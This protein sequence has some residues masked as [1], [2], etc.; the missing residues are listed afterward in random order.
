MPA[1]DTGKSGVMLDLHKARSAADVYEH[2]A[3]TLALGTLV[4]VTLRGGGTDTGIMATAIALTLP[5]AIVTKPW[6]RVHPGALVL[7]TAVPLTALVTALITPMAFTDS[8]DLAVYGYG[9]AA[10]LAFLGYASTRDRRRV[11]LVAAAVVG[12]IAF[13]HALL[14]WIGGGDPRQAMV[15]T[16]YELDMFGTFCVGS[17][18]LGFSLALF[19]DWWAKVA[20]W[21]IGPACAAGVILSTSRSAEALLVVVWLIVGVAAI[22][23]GPR[24]LRRA[25]QWLGLGILAVGTVVLLTSALIFPGAHVASPIAGTTSRQGGD[26]VGASFHN[27]AAYWQAGVDDFLSHPLIGQGFGSYGLTFDERGTWQP[28]IASSYAHNGVLQGLAEGGLLLGIPL[29]LAS[30]GL[31]W[32]SVRR[33]TRQMRSG[34][35]EAAAIG[36]SLAALAVLA[37]A[38]FDFDWTYPALAGLL[39]LAYACCGTDK[40]EGPELARGLVRAVYAPV[41]AVSALVVAVITI[42]PAYGYSAVTE[43]VTKAENVTSPAAQAREA[44]IVD[45]APLPF[46]ADAAP[47]MWVISTVSN[48]VQ[49]DRA[50]GVP[51]DL[52]LRALSQTASVGTID[53]STA[54]ERDL[55][56]FALGRRTVALTQAAQLAGTEGSRYPFLLVDYD[57]MLIRAD[58]PSEAEKL[59]ATEV[60]RLAV[61]RFPL[62]YD[63]LSMV[64]ELRGVAGP[65]SAL[66]RC[67]WS[68]LSRAFPQVASQ[69]T[70]PLASGPA[71]AGC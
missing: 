50:L 19:G 25:A 18:A 1:L 64:A 28:L 70:A 46:L 29:G 33:L 54:V 53:P 34:A 10:A 55:V 13:S 20:G 37:H 39:V 35:V 68:E 71:P 12:F 8:Q 24:R 11:L 63:V 48:N 56:I 41:I 51:A 27:R 52:V 59:L 26:S 36:G 22:R 43:A 3:V 14:P 45:S 21:V 16:F 17:A 57:L 69:L 44:R 62:P 40:E 60:H 61:P 15:G 6:R 5:A 23:G 38:M 32:A 47:G 4:W 66:T 30:L 49:S 31:A 42:Y 58:Q 67:A 7:L 65:R 2:V 9:A